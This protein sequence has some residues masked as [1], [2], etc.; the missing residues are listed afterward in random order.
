M[1]Y[2]A[3]PREQRR[4]A[5][6][7]TWTDII[8]LARLRHYEQEA[9]ISPPLLHYLIQARSRAI[10]RS[11]LFR[12]FRY[13]VYVSAREALPSKALSGAMLDVM[14]GGRERHH[15]HLFLMTPAQ[16]TTAA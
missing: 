10:C 4:H 7:R 2:Y 8:T 5:A 11:A 9:D 12:H 14:A 13:A 6:T 16:R 3:A 15:L 1:K